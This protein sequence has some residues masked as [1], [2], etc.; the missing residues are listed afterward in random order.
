MA[1]TPEIL[2]NLST[3][4]MNQMS[5]TLGP[6]AAQ[7]YGTG[8]NFSMPPVDA[9]NLSLRRSTVTERLTYPGEIP[10][11]YMQIS[12]AKYARLD[13][14]GGNMFRMSRL[15]PYQTIIL[16]L[17]RELVDSNDVQYDDEKALGVGAGNIVQGG[18]N[19]ANMQPVERTASGM[20]GAARA[21]AAAVA[22]AGGIGAAQAI[23]DRS[24]VLRGL[25]LTSIATT[26]AQLAGYT[27][28]QFVT[29]LL[30]G[31]KYKRHKFRW[32]IS[33]HNQAE[34]EKIRQIIR[35]INNAK[36]PG[37]AVGGALFTFPDVFTVSLWPNS[38]MMYKFKPAVV[39]NFTVDYSG[40]GGVPTFR[41]ST[42]INNNAPAVLNIEMSILELEYWLSGNYTDSN[43]PGDVHRGTP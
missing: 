16:P 29:V 34:A 37:V 21:S 23:I 33:A 15:D 4:V 3:G 1:M 41:T 26:G 28:N 39:E 42:Q 31:P 35:V 6:T 13:G 5:N 38:S 11:Y 32:Q 40:G 19:I 2:S 8:A 17:P 30:T 20:M 10:K 24:V 43:D 7:I 9:I 14:N 12:I 18:A 36:S 25:P 27:P 22:A